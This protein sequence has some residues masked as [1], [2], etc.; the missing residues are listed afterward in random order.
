[1]LSLWMLLLCFRFGFAL[2]SLWM[3]S[4]WMLLLCFRFGFALDSLCFR[5]G[6]ALDAVALEGNLVNYI[7]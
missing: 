1:M 3:L 7:F 4:L 6:F 2:D 5:F